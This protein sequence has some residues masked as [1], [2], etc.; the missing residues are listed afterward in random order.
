M[1]NTPTYG[2]PLVGKSYIYR[3]DAEKYT[4]PID[5]GLVVANGMPVMVLAVFTDWNL[6]L[7]HI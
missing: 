4:G 5:D 7:I 2:H 1:P 3:A 6:S